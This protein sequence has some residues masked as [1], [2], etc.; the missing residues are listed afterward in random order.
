MLQASAAAAIV[1]VSRPA[2][3]VGVLERIDALVYVSIP[4][5]VTH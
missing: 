2:S 1:F 3:G 4:H 5:G